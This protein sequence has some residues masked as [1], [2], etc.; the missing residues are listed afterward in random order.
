MFPIGATGRRLLNQSTRSRVTHRVSGRRRL[1][2]AGAL[3]S[4]LEG[5][6][7]GRSCPGI[8]AALA[9][10][11]IGRKLDFVE[12]AAEKCG[13]LVR[14]QEADSPQA[15][16]EADLPQAAREAEA[17]AIGEP[18]K[19]DADQDHLGKT[20]GQRGDVRGNVEVERKAIFQRYR[21]R[22]HEGGGLGRDPAGEVENRHGNVLSVL[23]RS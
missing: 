17:A 1:G 2:Q 18:G 4:V 3:P 15:P 11:V 10:Q 14:D 6:G 8:R 21:I 13:A 5:C 23:F 16:P 12:A 20:W 9:V 7:E 19:G 22:H